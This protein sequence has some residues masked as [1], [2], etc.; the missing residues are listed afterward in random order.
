M[1]SDYTGVTSFPTEVSQDDA[2]EAA[3]RQTYRLSAEDLTEEAR[4]PLCCH[5]NLAM[6]GKRFM[7]MME[8]VGQHYVFGGGTRLN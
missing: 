5:C 1:S 7:V 2:F 3:H 4:P 6:P 8:Q